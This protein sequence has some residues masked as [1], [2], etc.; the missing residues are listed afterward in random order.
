MRLYRSGRERALRGDPPCQRMSRSQF[1]TRHAA[2]TGR[3]VASRREGQRGLRSRGQFVTRHA[4]PT[5][6]VVTPRHDGR[7]V[8]VLSQSSTGAL[9]ERIPAAH[10][11]RCSPTRTGPLPK[12]ISAL[13]KRISAL[14]KVGR[15]A[16]AASASQLTPSSI[17]GRRPHRCRQAPPSCGRRPRWPP[18]RRVRP[19]GCACEPPP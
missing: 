16:V 5:G 15:G 9:L 13:L 2:R 11:Y 3:V 17:S 10:P 4:V 1:V 18:L 7:A 6:R 8:Q 19:A 14:P 12:R